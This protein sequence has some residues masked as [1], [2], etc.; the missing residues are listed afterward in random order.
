MI[1]IKAIDTLMDTIGELVYKIDDSLIEEDRH[2]KL[3]LFCTAIFGTDYTIPLDLESFA[4]NVKE[5]VNKFLFEKHNYIRKAQVI[6]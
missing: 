2:E 4:I 1:N 5:M 3:K 6:S